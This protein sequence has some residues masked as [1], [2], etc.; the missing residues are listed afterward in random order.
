MKN[1]LKDYWKFIFW[2]FILWLLFGLAIYFIFNNWTSRW[3]FW[4]MFW[5]FNA[6][7]SWLAFAVLVV[8]L[9]LQ[10]E[11]LWL[12]R[13][14]IR[15][16]RNEFIQQN[17]TMKLQRFENTF[18]QMIS[19]HNKISDN[20]VITIYSPEVRWRSRVFQYIVDQL[21]KIHTAN[22]INFIKILYSNI[23]WIDE[24]S[25]Y[26]RNLF[27]IFKLIDE[28]GFTDNDKLF[29]SNLLVAQLSGNELIVLLINSMSFPKSEYL[30]KKYKVYDSMG[31]KLLTDVLKSYIAS[32]PRVNSL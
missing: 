14:E 17:K 20:I 16:T 11:E 26:F 9:Y 19:L 12:Q 2:V 3:A 29:Y 22:G 8:T 32:P 13:G 25:H 5:A 4:D 28:S 7:F 30:T 31:S 24:L 18:F 15:E 1:L 10:K 6:L 27:Q 21:H 23:W